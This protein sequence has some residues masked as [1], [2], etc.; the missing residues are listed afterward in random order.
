MELCGHVLRAVLVEGST[1]WEAARQFGIDPRKVAKML[2]FSVPPGIPAA[3]AVGAAEG[4]IGSLGP[5]IR[6]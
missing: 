3:P 4:G 6:S 2:V 5:C 1:R